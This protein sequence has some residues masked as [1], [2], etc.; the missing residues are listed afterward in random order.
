MVHAFED[1]LNILLR[2]NP[3]ALSIAHFRVPGVDEKRACL[4]TVARL[5]LQGLY[6]KS[7]IDL[8]Y[9]LTRNRFDRVDCRMIHPITMICIARCIYFKPE[10]GAVIPTGALNLL[11]R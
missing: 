3:D 7:V 8:S 2:R 9:K 11:A 6:H 10:L 1:R 5:I 4:S